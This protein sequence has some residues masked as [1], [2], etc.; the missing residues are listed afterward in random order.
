MFSNEKL[1]IEI[2][3]VVRMTRFPIEVMRM[4]DRVHLSYR[5][6][7]AQATMG[8][9]HAFSDDLKHGENPFPVVVVT[10][11]MHQVVL[12]LHGDTAHDLTAATARLLSLVISLPLMEA[13]RLQPC[14]WCA[15]P[16]PDASAGGDP[17]SRAE[18]PTCQVMAA[19]EANYTTA[20]LSVDGAVCNA[21]LDDL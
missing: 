4:D 3:R 15:L 21:S 11:L 9:M 10:H 7:H 1:F 18:C 8:A 17:Q 6:S 20:L 13:S 5:G 2:C 14:R 16:I 12:F 19:S